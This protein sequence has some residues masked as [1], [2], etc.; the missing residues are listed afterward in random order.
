VEDK[1]EAD[2]RSIWIGNVCP[3]LLSLALSSWITESVNIR[4]RIQ[5]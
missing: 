5:E 4:C 2:A 1:Q 3:G